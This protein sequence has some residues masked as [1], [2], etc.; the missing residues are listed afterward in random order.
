MNGLL[1]CPDGFH[2]QCPAPICNVVYDYTI[3]SPKTDVQLTLLSPNGVPLSG[4]ETQT[5]SLSDGSFFLCGPLDTPFYVQA[6][7]ANYQPAESALLD[8]DG[9]PD[10]FFASLGEFAMISTQFLPAFQEILPVPFVPGSSMVVVYISTYT[11]GAGG[12]Q[13]GAALPD[14]GTLDGGLPFQVLYINQSGPDPNLTATTDGGNA[15]LYNIDP[16]LTNGF[17]A[18]TLSNPDA[19]ADCLTPIPARSN[20]TGLV[21]VSESSFSETVVPLN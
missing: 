16:T 17:I 5:T 8:E 13:V 1:A 10:N 20:E 7:A 6:M 18:I 15:I 21:P 2:T 12:I 14:G 3:G 4:S 9:G 11:C 19:G